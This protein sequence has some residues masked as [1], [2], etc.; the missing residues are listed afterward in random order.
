MLAREEVR[1]EDSLWGLALYRVWSVYQ[2][3]VLELDSDR[4]YLAGPNH[5][6]G[7]RCWGWGRISR[8]LVQ[9]YH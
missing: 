2:T 7:G 1:S 4:L 8:M 9:F 3:Q 5:V 6:R